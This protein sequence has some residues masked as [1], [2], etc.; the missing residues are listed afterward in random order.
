[1]V[2]AYDVHRSEMAQAALMSGTAGADRSV[3]K[4]PRN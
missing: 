4:K 1:M 3:L 2:I